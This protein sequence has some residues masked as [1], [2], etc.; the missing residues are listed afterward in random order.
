MLFELRDLSIYFSDRWPY[1]LFC[2]AVT[3]TYV[4]VIRTQNK[5]R[6]EKT[7]DLPWFTIVPVGFHMNLDSKSLGL[8]WFL[9]CCYQPYQPPDFCSDPVVPGRL[10]VVPHRLEESPWGRSVPPG[11]PPSRLVVIP[12]SLFNTPQKPWF[13]GDF[14]WF[15][16]I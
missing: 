1:H 16:T 4:M 13:S 12:F 15:G 11:G 8:W 10:R 6:K 7:S 3:V 14:H 2:L 5:D 9:G